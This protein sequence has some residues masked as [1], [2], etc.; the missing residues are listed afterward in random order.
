MM[1]GLTINEIAEEQYAWVEDM[2]WHNK[3]PLE[4]VALIGS[5]VG[6]VANECRQEEPSNKTGEELADILLRVLD[7]AVVYGIDME[8]EIQKKMAINYV[9]GNRGRLK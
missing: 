2:G 4:Y 7:M 5:E 6:E 1:D 3:R 8:I 9:R